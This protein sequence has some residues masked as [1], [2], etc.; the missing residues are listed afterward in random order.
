MKKIIAILSIFTCL[1][2]FAVSIF[3]FRPSK[4]SNKWAEKQIKKMSVDEKVGQLVHIGIN[5]KYAHQNSDFFKEIQRNIVENKLGGIVVFAGGL[6][7]TV[8]FVNRMQENAKIPLLISA[9]FETGVGMR[10]DETVNFP[11]NMAVAATGNPELA[12]KQGEIV[13]REAKALGVYQVYAPVVDVNNNADN[14]VINTR[15][16]GENPADVARFAVAFTQGLQSQ[17][18][19]ATAKHFPGHGDTNVDSHRGLPIIDVDKKRLDAVELV[20]FKA[21]IDA[22]IGSVMIAHIGLPQIDPTQIKPLKQSINLDTDSAFANENATMPS[23]L[24]PLINTNILHKELKFDGLTVTD[25]MSMSGLTQYFNQDEAAV[26]AVLAG[27]DIL[28]KP[29]NVE[30]TL[31]GLREAVNSGRISQEKLNESVKKQL[32]WKHELGLVKN[33]ITPLTEIDKIVSSTET[34]NLAEEIA[35]NAVT[36][37]KNENQILPLEKGKQISLLC[38]T[39]G[40]DRNFVGVAFA[41]TLRSFGLKVERIVLEERSNAL[42]IE[43][44]INRMKKADVVIAGLYGRVRSGAKNS[45]GLPESGLKVLREAFV[46]NKPTIGIAFGNPYFLRDFPEFSTYI[47]AF[48]DMGSLQRATANALTGK[49]EFVGKLPITI[50]KYPRGTGLKLK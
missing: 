48:G 3:A 38:I 20:P 8:H 47:A 33:K 50:G 18:I 10:F 23:T 35:K 27:S 43:N 5:A 45:V 36:L 17:K 42:E 2:L 21:V 28:E 40:E 25:A 22:G 7:E 24:S 26:L 9:D 13:G 30:L 12:R 46:T 11:W 49:N 31:K 15:S 4:K 37:V 19:I 1:N 14:P 41:T 29:A 32:A 6:Y 34:V 16:Y 39:N 44:A